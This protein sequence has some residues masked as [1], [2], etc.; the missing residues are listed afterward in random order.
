VFGNDYL[1][2][3]TGKGAR[4]AVHPAGD[5]PFPDTFGYNAPPG[6]LS[7]FGMRLVCY[8]HVKKHDFCVVF[9]HIQQTV[10]RMPWPNDECLVDGKPDDYIYEDYRYSSEVKSWIWEV[11]FQTNKFSVCWCFTFNQGCYRTCWQRTLAMNCSCSDPAY[12]PYQNFST[13]KG[14]DFRLSMIMII[15]NII[16]YWIFNIHYQRGMCKTDKNVHVNRRF[17]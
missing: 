13:C 17:W 14:D 11:D 12:P 7:Q 5:Y 16:F 8:F 15:K 9:S 10:R 1:P 3:T 2:M 4:I 6:F